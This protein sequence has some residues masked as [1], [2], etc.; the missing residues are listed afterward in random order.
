M[1]AK[2]CLSL[3]AYVFMVGVNALASLLPLNNITTAEI[4]TSTRP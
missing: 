1:R 2:K 3:V 4:S